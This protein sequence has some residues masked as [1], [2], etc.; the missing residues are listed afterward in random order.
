MLL[1]LMKYFKFVITAKRLPDNVKEN[2]VFAC[3]ELDLNEVMVYGFDYD[4]T[5]ACYKPSLDYLI[6]NLARLKLHRFY[7][8]RN[9]YFKITI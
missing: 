1:F 8:V 4:Y 7:Q 5:L 2:A 6:Y 9:R 3:N